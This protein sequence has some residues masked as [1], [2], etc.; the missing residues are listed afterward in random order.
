MRVK[1]IGLALLALV[2]LPALAAAQQ[3][4]TISGK[5]VDSGGG[6]LPGVTIEAR[7]DVMPAPRVTTSGEVGDYRLPA[8]LPGTY[9]VSYV[10]AGMGTVTRTVQVQL[11]Q[12]TVVNI[13]L[14]VEGVQE[15][16]TVTAAIV[17]VIEK[18]ST[19]LKSAVSADAIAALPIG[20]EY[21]DLVKLIPGVM[22][23]QDSVRGP[24]SGG[25]GQDNTYKLDGVNVT[26]PLFG[27][28]S[29]EPASHDIAQV[30]TVKGGA[31]AVDFDRS[32]G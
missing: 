15:S 32:G 20:Q 23:T 27:T 10:L 5:V 17:P 24:S 25:S 11:A 8:L 22:Y 3:T 12:D 26:L 18:D 30:T 2:L 21:R 13:T 28:L 31:K 6:V 1:R 19:A 7:A 9:T 4:G 16:V 29:A 14:N